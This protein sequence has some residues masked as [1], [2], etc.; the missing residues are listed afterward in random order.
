MAKS[1]RTKGNKTEKGMEFEW[2]KK[3]KRES[4]KARENRR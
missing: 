1:F 2:I 3:S 4:E